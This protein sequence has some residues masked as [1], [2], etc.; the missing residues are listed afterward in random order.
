[1]ISLFFRHYHQSNK[2]QKVKKLMCRQLGQSRP[3][4]VVPLKREDEDD[5]RHAPAIPHRSGSLFLP[6]GLR[7]Q[8]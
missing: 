8:A 4:A 3:K 1:M 7:W 2:K 6:G 5:A